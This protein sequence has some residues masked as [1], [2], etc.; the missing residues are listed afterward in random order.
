MGGILFGVVVIAGG[1]TRAGDALLDPL[2]A[3]VRRRAFLPAVSACRIV[4]AQLGSDAGVIGAAG[5]F[6]AHHGAI[7]EGSVPGPAGQ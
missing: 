6:L 4:A 3:E 1:V 7:G 2:R 5:I